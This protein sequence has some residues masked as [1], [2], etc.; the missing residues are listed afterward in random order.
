MPEDLR[1][2][3]KWVVRDRGTTIEMAATLRAIAEE[4]AGEDL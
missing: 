4:A 2:R 3:F 1:E